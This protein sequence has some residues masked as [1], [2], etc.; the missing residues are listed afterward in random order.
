MLN[1]NTAE[2]PGFDAKIIGPSLPKTQEGNTYQLQNLRLRLCPI[3]TAV[4]TSPCLHKGRIPS[5][6]SLPG[7]NLLCL[8]LLYTSGSHKLTQAVSA[9][10]DRDFGH[11]V[12][13][14]NLASRC[15]PQD[16]LPCRTKFA[17]TPAPRYRHR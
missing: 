4:Y 10:R 2:R 5:Y 1:M 16:H 8:L 11:L 9:K 15:S 7:A 14:V 3:Y 6:V 17:S 13:R 12:F